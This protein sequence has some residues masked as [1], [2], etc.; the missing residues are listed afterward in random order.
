MKEGDVVLTPIPQADGMIKNRPAI[1]LREM[2]P[3]LRLAMSGGEEPLQPCFKR[4]KIFR[5]ALPNDHHLP[6]FTPQRPQ[7]S[8]ISFHI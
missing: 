3:S 6:P 2:P 1:V 8:P 4:H 7:I 5:L